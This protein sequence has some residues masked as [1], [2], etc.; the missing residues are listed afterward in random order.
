MQFINQ[1]FDKTILGITIL[2]TFFAS[3]AFADS[4]VMDRVLVSE[5]LEYQIAEVIEERKFKIS[6]ILKIQ[7]LTTT[8][9]IFFIFTSTETDFERIML[10][11][12]DGRWKKAEFK[13]KIISELKNKD[14]VVADDGV[15]LHLLFE[16]FER[17]Y[18]KSEYKLFVKTF[19][20]SMY[21]G[22]NFQNFEGKVSG[23]IVSVTIKDP[24]N[25]IK[26]DF[27]GTVKNG[28]FEGSVYVPENIWQRGWY[29]VDVEIQYDGK[30]Y[31]KQLSFYVF[32]ES[33]TN[34][35]LTCSEG[36]VKINGSCV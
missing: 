36:T 32:G 3:P 12:G 13:T 33:S 29:T 23:A 30:S 27:G 10:L 1:N 11:D 8:G 35:G 6:P 16:Q 21:S 9:E 31:S 2:L 34:N 14:S 28:V 26:K 25:E 18:N 24:N 19:D 7:G 15:E 17:V 5:N 4:S 22:N 20:K